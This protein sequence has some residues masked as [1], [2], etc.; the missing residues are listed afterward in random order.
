MIAQAPMFGAIYVML[1]L[2]T[3]I[4]Q[5]PFCSTALRLRQF[6]ATLQFYPTSSDAAQFDNRL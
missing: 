5:R 1:C 2:L 4:A 6:D 3:L